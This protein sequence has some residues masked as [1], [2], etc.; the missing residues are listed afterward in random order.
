MDS[1]TKPVTLGE[2]AAG[3]AG[4]RFDYTMQRLVDNIRDLNTD[5]TAKR[6]IMLEITMQPSEDRETIATSIKVNTTMPNLKAHTMPMFVQRGDDGQLC[7]TMFKP[8]KEMDL[9]ED[10]IDIRDHIKGK[11]GSQ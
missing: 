11:V 10:Q 4:E 1:H 9:D 7:F 6:K 8:Q 3:A 5:A 2:L